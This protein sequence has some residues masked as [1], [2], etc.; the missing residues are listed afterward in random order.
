LWIERVRVQVDVRSEH[1][2]YRRSSV[3]WFTKRRYITCVYN[4]LPLP[5]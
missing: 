1:V 2:P 5:L 4:L 3:Y